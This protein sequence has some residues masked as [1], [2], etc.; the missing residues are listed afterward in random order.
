MA[1]YQENPNLY[2]KCNCGAL[3]FMGS[4]LIATCSL[5]Y[6]FF[7]S[8]SSPKFP[9]PIFFPT[10]KVE[11]KNSEFPCMIPTPPTDL[12]FGPT[13]STEEEAV[14]PALFVMLDLVLLLVCDTLKQQQH[15]KPDPYQDITVVNDELKIELGIIAINFCEN[16]MK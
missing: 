13:I 7:P 3:D 12:K 15:F 16:W 11:D 8:L 2:S 4:S 10:L 6:R 14:P 9:Q 5:L 1:L